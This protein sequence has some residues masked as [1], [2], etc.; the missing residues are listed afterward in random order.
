KD[1]AAVRAS[2]GYPEPWVVIWFEFGNETYHGDHRGRQFTPEEYARRYLRYQRAMKAVDPRVKLGA[3]VEYVGPW[4]NGVAKVC[5]REMD[6][7]ITHTYVP[8][9]TAEQ[10]VNWPPRLVAQACAAADYQIRET[11]KGLREMVKRVCGRDHVPIAVT[12]YNGHFVQE[13]P[14]PYRQSLAVA[15]RNADHIRVML[16][17]AENILMANFWQFSNEYWG[18]VRGY[19]HKGERPVKQANF[20]VYQMYREHFG[21]VILRSDVQCETW[22]FEGG[23]WLKAR[24]GKGQRYQLL[25]SNL[26]SGQPWRIS[27]TPEVDQ[28][29]EEDGR[30]VAVTFR[31]GQ[32]NYYHASIE[33]PAEPKTG[34]H[35]VGCIKTQNL[36]AQ[37]GAGFQVGDARGWTETHSATTFGN[38]KGTTDGWVRVAGDS[39][40]IQISARRLDIGDT[41]AG[42]AWYRIES[43]QKFLPDVY[44]GVP[45]V[46][47]IATR[48]AAD[49]AIC[50][51]IIHTD[52][53]ADTPLTVIPHGATAR[54]AKAWA[55]TGPSPEATN[56]ESPDMVGVR[57][58]P[59]DVTARGVRL[60]LPKY[61]VVALEV[62]PAGR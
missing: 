10:I 13:N 3:T 23:C 18:M 22:D 60:T 20:F 41:C 26:Y 9:A 36:Q 38:V 34:Y 47:A 29:L 53:D 7:L 57:E 30:V 46:K 6:F 31:G 21:D 58:I 45:Y 62:Q 8:G 51:M 55:L 52:L 4:G 11:Y 17:P 27:A 16:D 59:C 2:E 37:M 54:S 19:V 15:L 40:A 43:V 25:P 48:R 35:V 33:L 1:W 42:K 44:P 28:Q 56:L 12:E 24:R 61:S 32:F 49:G 39:T 50:L 14:V 5:G